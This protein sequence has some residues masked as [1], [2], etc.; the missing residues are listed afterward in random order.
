MLLDYSIMVAGRRPMSVWRMRGTTF[1]VENG[2]CTLHATQYGGWRAHCRCCGWDDWAGSPQSV[3]MD[4]AYAHIA[5]CP[6]ATA[7]VLDEAPSAW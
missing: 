6:K 7:A 4:T 1:L 2:R 3:A 5:S